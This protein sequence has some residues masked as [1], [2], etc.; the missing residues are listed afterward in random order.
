MRSPKNPSVCS[1]KLPIGIQ[2]FEKL[3][4]QDFKYVDKTGF[5]YHLVHNNVPYFLSRPRRFGKSLLI[6]TLKAYWLGQ[7]ELFKGLAIE[8]LEETNPNAWEPYPVFHFDFNRDDYMRNGALE[9]VL[10]QHL[11][12]WEGQYGCPLPNASLAIRFQNLLQHVRT[13]TG[14][15]CV[16]LID[17][18]D[19]PL[20]DLIDQQEQ[21]EHNKAVMKGFFSSLKSCDSYIQFV[22]ITGVSKFNK[23][24]IFSDLNHLKDISMNEEYAG[25]C[26]ITETELL[27]NFSSEIDCLADKQDLPRDKCLGKLKETY[28]GYHFHPNGVGVYNPFSLLNA[29]SDGDFASYWFETGT[30]TFLVNLIRRSGFDVRKF[31]DGTLFAS[32][33]ML[34]EYKADKPDPLPL[35]YQTGYLTIVGYDRENRYFTLGYPNAEV[36]YGFTENL[37]PAFSEDYGPGTGTDIYTLSRHLNNG[38]LDGVRNVLVALFAR[39]TYSASGD[40]PFEHYFQTVIY[41]VLTLLGKLVQCESHTYTGRIDCTVETKKFIYLFEFKRDATARS[42]LDQIE[43]NQYALIYAADP[44]KL[45]KIGVNFDSEKRMLTEWEVL[46]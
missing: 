15:L 12:E 20:L 24:S 16:I 4:S 25:I 10:C 1:H 40:A 34:S 30:P 46:E 9:D 21:L 31:T 7:K 3:I 27:D 8:S 35:L 44:R 17:E 13:R 23:V 2:S 5:I 26:G 43:C 41:L 37:L 22:F 14:Q 19:K 28:D 32:E 39:I 33:G 42:A 18:Y 36:K 29:L 11:N 45:F 6:S 38:D